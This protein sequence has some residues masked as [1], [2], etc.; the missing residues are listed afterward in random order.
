MGS[1]FDSAWDFA[2]RLYGNFAM[3]RG[4][5]P[6]CRIGRVS[7]DNTQFVIFGKGKTWAE[8]MKQ[9]KDSKIIGTEPLD[10]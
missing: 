6:N 9:A 10:S 1:G 5:T 7:D 2:C 4:Q 3:L 8:A